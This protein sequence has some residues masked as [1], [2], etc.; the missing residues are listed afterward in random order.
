VKLRRW[1][2]GRFGEKDVETAFTYSVFVSTVA[3]IMILS[4]IWVTWL[5]VNGFWIRGIDLLDLHQS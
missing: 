3:V 1:S 2:S 4:R 5:I